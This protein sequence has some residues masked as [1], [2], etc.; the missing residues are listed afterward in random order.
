MVCWISQSIS[1]AIVVYLF[2]QFSRPV[3][4]KKAGEGESDSDEDER[5]DP[6]LDYIGV[7]NLNASKKTIANQYL[8][9]D[10]G[11]DGTLQFSIENFEKEIQENWGEQEN[12]L[13]TAIYCSFIKDTDTNLLLKKFKQRKSNYRNSMTN[14]EQ[15]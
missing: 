4:F 11:L 9:G 1:Q 15:S 6:N 7:S 5:R 8:F 10:E 3:V 12:Q 2:V 14:L 13:R